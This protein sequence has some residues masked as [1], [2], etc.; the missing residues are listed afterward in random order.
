VSFRPCGV[1]S[2][3]KV[4]S[5]AEAADAKKVFPNGVTVVTDA[6][7]LHLDPHLIQKVRK[8]S[9]LEVLAMLERCSCNEI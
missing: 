4:V 1:G 9:S 8:C 2:F 5:E 6:E 7:T 3:K